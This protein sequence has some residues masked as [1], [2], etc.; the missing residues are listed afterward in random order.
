MGRPRL[1]VTAAKGGPSNNQL[2]LTRAHIRAR[3]TA[4]G[5]GRARRRM[6][7]TRRLRRRSCSPSFMRPCSLTGCSAD[8]GRVEVERKKRDLG[9]G[10]RRH[11]AG[12]LRPE[13]SRSNQLLCVREHGVSRRLHILVRRELWSSVSLLYSTK[14]LLRGGGAPR[15]SRSRCSARALRP[16]SV[17]ESRH[18]CRPHPHP[19]APPRRRP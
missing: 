5:A 12:P 9:H 10:P 3:G 1:S 19:V 18:V 4:K 13:P 17:E 15:R 6:L 8:R 7:A 2:K 11:R 16:S 14:G